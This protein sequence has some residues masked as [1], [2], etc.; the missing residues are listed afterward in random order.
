MNANTMNAT[1]QMMIAR[2]IFDDPTRTFAVQL[3]DGSLLPGQQ[4]LPALVLR[5]ESALK[6]LLPPLEESSLARA[7]GRGD[8]DIAG[9]PVSL[10]EAVACWRGPSR[11]AQLTADGLRTTLAWV[12]AD[13]VHRLRR[14]MGW[15]HTK[16]HDERA[17]RLHYDLGDEFFRL[18][19]D[20]SMT[21]SCAYFSSGDESL[22]EAQ[23]NKLELVTR[24]LGLGPGQTL[25]D[26]GCGWGSLVD[27][28]SR[29]CGATAC[30]ITISENQFRQAKRRTLS[31]GATVMQRDYREAPAGPFDRAVSIG[32]MEHV[33]GRQLDCYFRTVYERLR[34]GG[35]FLN[36][37]V[38]DIADD[39]RM[40]PWLASAAGGFVLGDIFPESEILPLAAVVRAAEKSGF[41][42]RDVESLRE[43][44][45]RTLGCWI[46]NLEARFPEAASLVGSELARKWRLYLAASAAAF[47]VGTVGVYQVLLAKR[48]GHGRTLGL[49]RS[50]AEWYSAPFAAPSSAPPSPCA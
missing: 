22:A 6:Y 26:I 43:H 41:E 48:D 31:P 14:A 30:G 44:Y 34:P 12:A 40:V 23:R 42:V 19:L 1:P 21:Y 24:K 5:S 46:A 18:F 11:R 36:H 28:A 7:F 39:G 15:S 47:R 25:L 35:L 32:M 8:L 10:L 45:A 16:V 20:E 2:A 33:G 3:W 27:Y 29:R 50:R 13:F 37:A 49:P 38:A 9:D 17:I 4:G